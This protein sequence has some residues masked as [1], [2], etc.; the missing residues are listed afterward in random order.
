MTKRSSKYA[1]N[2]SNISLLIFVTQIINN[3]ETSN[4]K[5]F[6]PAMEMNISLVDNQLS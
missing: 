6:P 5:S 2:V 4:L 1:N 3:G